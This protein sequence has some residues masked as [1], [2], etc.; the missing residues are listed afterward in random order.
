M[1][2]RDALLSASKPKPKFDIAVPKKVVVEAEN[3]E[4]TSV[5]VVVMTHLAR[6]PEV[7]PTRIIPIVWNDETKWL[8]SIGDYRFPIRD[9]IK[10]YEAAL[11]K[12]HPE[13]YH[14]APIQYTKPTGSPKVPEDLRIEMER[15]TYMADRAGP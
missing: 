7:E 12:G 15:L 2:R 3:S 5:L 11:K 6:H 13:T 1:N 10:G 9:E 8:L 14:V 4:P